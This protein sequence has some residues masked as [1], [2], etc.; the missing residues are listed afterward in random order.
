MQGTSCEGSKPN[1][2]FSRMSGHLFR[3]GSFDRLVLE[4]ATQGH[5][6]LSRGRPPPPSTSLPY[7]SPRSLTWMVSLGSGDRG[8]FFAT[9]RSSRPRSDTECIRHGDPRW[10]PGVM[11][12]SV[13]SQVQLDHPIMHSH[14]LRAFKR[15]QRALLYTAWSSMTDQAPGHSKV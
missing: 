2:Q 6:T 8:L 5:S 9:V 3:R 11:E 12:C 14:S 15:Y 1:K 13:A 10:I 4:F 7:A